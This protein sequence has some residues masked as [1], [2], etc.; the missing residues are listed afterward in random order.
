MDDNSPL[1]VLKYILDGMICNYH[2][3]KKETEYLELT[4]Q[5]NNKFLKLVFFECLKSSIPIADRD[6]ILNSE[7]LIHVFYKVAVNIVK[8]KNRRYRPMWLVKEYIKL[9]H[10]SRNP[11]IPNQEM[12][13][14]VGNLLTL[15]IA[16]QN[17]THI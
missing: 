10:K 4:K 17:R 11:K 9:A 15:I 5:T 6:R 12:F 3:G 2:F 8:Q 16:D 7:G 1:I 14:N 13:D